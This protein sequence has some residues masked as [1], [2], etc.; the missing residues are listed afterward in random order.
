VTPDERR[1]ISELFQAALEIGD[2]SGPLLPGTVVGSYTIEQE[3]GR[4]GMGRVYA[5]TDA[6]LRRRVALKAVAPHP[7]AGSTFRDRLRRE[8]LAAAALTHPGIC[9]VYALEEIDGQMFMATELIDGDTLRTEITSGPRPSGEAVRQLASEL[10]S[11]LAAAHTRG[12]IHRD[13]KPENIMRTRDGRLKI[14]DFGLARVESLAEPP[15]VVTRPDVILGTPS[16]M[17]PEQLT[18]GQADARADVFAFGVVLYEYTC[19][20]HPFAGDTLIA[21]VARVLERDVQPLAERSPQASLD[22]SALVDRCLKKTPEARFASGGEIAAAL[23][24]SSNDHRRPAA[25]PMT[26]RSI[27]RGAL[28]WWR[29]HQL[30]LMMIYILASVRAWDIKE[31]LRTPA[32]TMIFMGLGLGAAIAGGLRGHLIFTERLNRAHLGEECRRTSAAIRW[33]EL[34]MA[35]ALLADATQ[36]AGSPLAAVWTLALAALLGLAALVFDPATTRAVIDSQR[37]PETASRAK[38]ADR[39]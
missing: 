5:A 6:R 11:A 10:A 7:D 1:R 38:P 31:W 21:T 28:L 36:L 20:E 17:A 29:T 4:G 26:A 15:A 19:G 24:A 16:Y 22:I 27:G 13:L 33:V 14:L 25:M 32:T 39:T 37:L 30:A 8:A 12:V 18:G 9:T 35:T 34:L 23:A 3:L 2:P